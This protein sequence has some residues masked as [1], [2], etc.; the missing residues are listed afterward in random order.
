[1]QQRITCVVGIDLGDRWS[2]VGGLDKRTGEVWPHRRVR[3]EPGAMEELFSSL[4]APCRVVLETGTHSPWISRVAERHGHEVVV[5][6]AR[7]LRAIWQNDRKSDDADVDILWQIADVRP[8]L[9]HPI[10]HRSA[11]S[12]WDLSLL[13]LREQLVGSRTKLVNSVRGTVKALGYRVVKCSP[14]TFA[15]RA[16][17]ELPVRVRQLVAPLLAA[18]AGL[19]AQVAE[20]DARI[21][22]LIRTTYRASTR[23]LLAVNGVGPVTALAYVLVLDDPSRFTKS[24]M[25]GAYAGLVPRRDQSGACDRQLSISKSGDEM[26]RR[27]LVQCAHHIL[28]YRGRDSDL[29]RWGLERAERGGAN[30]KKKAVVGVAR[31]L[32]VLLHRLWVD[33]TEYEPLR[34]A[35]RTEQ[36]S[37][38]M[39]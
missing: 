37:V 11:Q 14:E 38:A 31:R 4:P 28:G 30:A 12:Q 22:E 8:E 6:Q 26:L 18:I 35:L 39:V 23:R 25:V 27:L 5:G 20:Y 34:Q 9:L 19:S 2:V 17:A 24:R 15:Q 33:D 10:Q 16:A 21:K 7:K 36:T 13:R 3:T 1:M 29:R 32:A